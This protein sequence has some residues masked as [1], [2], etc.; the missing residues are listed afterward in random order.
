ML[1]VQMLW[2]WATAYT[3]SIPAEE[4]DRGDGVLVWV[5][6]VAAMV[7]AALVVVALVSQKSQDTVTN[8]KTQ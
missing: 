2:A 4:R 3:N 7:V 1:Q 5:V 8:I 6:V